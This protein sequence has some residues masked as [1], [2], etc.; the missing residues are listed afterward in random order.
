[1]KPIEHPSKPEGYKRLTLDQKKPSLLKIHGHDKKKGLT[2][3][4]SKVHLKEIEALAGGGLSGVPTTR[5]PSKESRLRK[6][7]SQ[8]HIKQS[9]TKMAV[10][11]SSRFAR[12][13]ED[14]DNQIKTSLEI[15]DMDSFVRDVLNNINLL[16]ASESTVGKWLGY[17]KLCFERLYAVSEE[18]IR[19]YASAAEEISRLRH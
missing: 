7:N 17:F 12:S 15:R 5:K 10:R 4:K 13:R 11:P 2:R 14:I 16:M 3:S 6:S 18:Y 1:M 9:Q 8:L 19:K